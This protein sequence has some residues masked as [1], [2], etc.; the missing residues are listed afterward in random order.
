[1]PLK[2]LAVSVEKPERGRLKPA[3]ANKPAP[4]YWRDGTNQGREK[5]AR[6]KNKTKCRVSVFS[7]GTAQPKAFAFSG[8]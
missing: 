6:Q 5:R 2:L 4:L 3:Q 8:I 1:V 7:T